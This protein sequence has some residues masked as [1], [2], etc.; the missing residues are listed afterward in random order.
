MD[1]KVLIRSNN[2][3]FSRTFERDLKQHEY[4]VKSTRAK[5]GELIKV[6]AEVTPDLTILDAPL[7][8]IEGIRELLDIRNTVNAPLVMLCTQGTKAD[9]V[10]TLSMGT[11]NHLSLKAVTFED[12]LAQINKLLQKQ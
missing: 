5:N 2:S 7:V 8:H 11:A 4:E 9:T 6:L 3:Y 12:L 1:K 10:T